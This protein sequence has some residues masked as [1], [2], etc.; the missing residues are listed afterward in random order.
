MGDHVMTEPLVIG[1]SAT[2]WAKRNGIH[3]NFSARTNGYPEYDRRASWAI[4]GLWTY[5]ENRRGE[6]SRRAVIA[7]RSAFPDAE[8]ALYIVDY[9]DAGTVTYYA[10]AW[11]P[12]G[13]VIL[14][15]VSSAPTGWELTPR[16]AYHLRTF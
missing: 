10:G 14:V 8:N 11:G 6:N 1:N 12:D 15:D 4:G 16:R 3:F 13:S 5:V 7:D 9:G 2:E